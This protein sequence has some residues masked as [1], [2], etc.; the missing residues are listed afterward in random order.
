MQLIQLNYAT[1]AYTYWELCLIT[2]ILGCVD[3]ENE[4]PREL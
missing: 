1:D 2:K 3:S 4:P